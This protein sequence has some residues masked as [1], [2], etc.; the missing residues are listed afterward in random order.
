V[1][2]GDAEKRLATVTARLIVQGAEIGLPDAPHQL[3]TAAALRLLASAYVELIE[4]VRSLHG[5]D[6]TSPIGAALAKAGLLRLP[7]EIY[8]R[9]ELHAKL[10]QTLDSLELT[11]RSANVLTRT[12]VCYVGELVQADRR[13]LLRL[14]NFGKRSLQEIE[15]KL[16]QRQL[17]LGAEID[18]WPGPR[19]ECA[20]T[21]PYFR[22]LG[23]QLVPSAL[24]D[25]CTAASD[26]WL[27]LYCRVM[28]E[29]PGFFSKHESYIVRVWDGMDGCW[30]DCTK[31]VTR[32]EALQRWAK[33][34]DRG[35]QRVAYNEID[36]YR[37]FPGSTNMLWDG[38]EGMEMHR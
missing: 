31:A 1:K 8:P 4:Q 38:S 29:D 18:E 34:T 2:L 23:P 14:K 5:L 22:K 24:P 12:G 32:D 33:E 27:D 21:Y 36:Y 37:I 20:E 15:E 35:T 9:A 28:H 19:W 3:V 17:H 11:V 30:T 10:W 16:T 25:T 26:P 13:T 6:P 7:N